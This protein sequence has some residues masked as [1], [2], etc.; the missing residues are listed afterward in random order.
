M[1]PRTVLLHVAIEAEIN[2]LI[3]FLIESA[4]ADDQTRAFIRKISGSDYEIT[5]ENES[6]S[7]WLSNEPYV[8][9]YEKTMANRSYTIL[10]F[11]G[12]MLQMSYEI[13]D[14]KVV[15]SRM[16]YL[17]NPR[18]EQFAG[19]QGEFD[20]PLY[21]DLNDRRILPVPIRFEFDG[22]PGVAVAI[23][24]PVS[25]VTIGQFEG[26][27]IPAS[28]AITPFLFIDFVLRSFYRKAM[29]YCGDEVPQHTLRF[30]E[31][32]DV[33][34]GQIVHWGIPTSLVQVSV[35]NGR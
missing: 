8:D 10:L 30:P 32:L 21:A 1:N 2:G 25:H 29:D 12:A 16:A 3:A 27:R 20:D 7:D 33:L 31:C 15:R 19:G 14:N 28:A 26:C 9:V 6:I 13:S 24:H 23:H 5:F 35:K 17:P 4:L 34:E 18:L 22:R 11:D